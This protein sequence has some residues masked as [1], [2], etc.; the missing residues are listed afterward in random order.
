MDKIPRSTKLYR[1]DIW[2]SPGPGRFRS[3]VITD[4]VR[5]WAV[6][7]GTAEPLGQGCPPGQAKLKHGASSVDSP[8]LIP[9]LRDMNTPSTP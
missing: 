2:A 4:G 6:G 9:I 1:S 7:E 8:E 3:A 5:V